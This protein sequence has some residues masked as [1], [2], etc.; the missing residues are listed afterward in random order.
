MATEFDWFYGE[1]PREGRRLGWDIETNGLLDTV[2][3][4]HSL[5]IEDIDT[6]ELWSCCD[7]PHL[8]GTKGVDEDGRE[9]RYV[10]IKIGLKLLEAAAITFGHNIIGYDLMVLKLLVKGFKPRGIH[11]D[12]LMLAKMIWPVDNLK[13][14]DFP[15]WRKGILPGQ[16]IGAHK[17]EAWGYRLG[18][19]KGEYSA[20][21]KELN[22]LF[23]ES[24]HD[25]SVVPEEYHPLFTVDDK[26]VPKLYEWH[27]WCQPMQ[28]YC[29]VDVKVTLKLL[30]LIITH[31]EGTAKP[32]H[33]I[34]WS[35]R[36][37]KLEADMWQLCLDIQSNGFGYDLETAI[38][39]T[40]DLKT[41]QG[42][43]ERELKAAFGSWWQPLDDPKVGIKPAKDYS[44]ARKDL[45]D[46]T[47]RRFSEKTGK[48]LK[49]YIGP[50]KA[51]YS[52]EAAYVRIKWTE[53]NPKSRQHL[54]DRLQAVF[55]WQPAEFGG[56]KGDQAK[57]DETTIK[58][59][60][61]TVLPETLKAVILEYL[62]VSKTLGQMAD[63][64]KSWNDLCAEDG[65]LHGRI[66][67]LGTVSHRGAH[68]DPNL[69]Q[70][71][72]VSIAETKDKTGK[73][74]S[75]EIIYGWR[76]GFGA[77]CRSL[78]RPVR[79]KEGWTQTGT[80]AAGLELRLLGHAL[81]PYDDGEF[82]R[83]V[84]S[85]G[86]DIHAENAKITGLSRAE[87]KTAT[88]AFLYGAGNL[89]LGQQVGVSPEEVD[90][91]ADHA[92]AK[93]YVT[94]AKKNIPN[95]ETPDRQTMAF[96]T[97][98]ADVKRRFMSGITGL[99][100]LQA[101]VVTEGKQFG[102]IIALDGRKLSIRKAH[103]SLN[104]LLQGGGSIVCKKW[105]LEMKVVLAEWGY[106]PGRDYNY[107]GWI[108]DEAQI[109][110]R[111]GLEDIIRDASAEA[112]NRVAAYYDFRGELGTDSKSGLNW[113]DCH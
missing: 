16:L 111:P 42:E 53:F 94:W 15:R 93:R 6:G 110:H 76:G 77:E 63:G 30:R 48:E 72:S 83:R 8:Y 57:V 73:V 70:T 37:V 39:L 91:L 64:R 112:M 33:G 18:L 108:H 84:S 38:V 40:S 44:E 105:L 12:T 4:I 82:A 20:K 17:L 2:T 89:N 7:Q 24:G 75:K 92:D 103:A 21:V 61:E 34:G 88:Y 71:P 55:G 27:A 79:Y 60:P 35:P 90:E 9:F 22:K 81:W 100:D 25:R 58:G 68:M 113:K 56:A 95:F 107:M 52:T 23:Q 19:Q 96:I 13:Q 74:I 47:I 66:D 62:V 10:S 109:E 29:V 51:H 45:P 28:D 80:D 41:R 65:A 67:P 87:T 32:A 101:A 97:K 43:L 46:V 99:K 78:F 69:G 59:I 14:L 102:F 26:G 86:L 3:T 104:Q 11:R 5:V 85:P 54:G 98:G 49:P 36:S 31:L 50:P 106:L 1:T